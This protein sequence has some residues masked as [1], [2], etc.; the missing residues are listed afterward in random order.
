MSSRGGQDSFVG[1]NLP[2]ALNA[3][4]AEAAGRH[5]PGTHGGATASA[6]RTAPK[7]SASAWKRSGTQPGEPGRTVPGV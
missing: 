2:A 4:G 1:L 7:A 6:R 3:P 5:H